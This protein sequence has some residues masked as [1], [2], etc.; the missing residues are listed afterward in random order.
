MDLATNMVTGAISILAAS[1]MFSFHYPKPLRVIKRWW[2]HRSIRI[3]VSKLNDCKPGCF[4][5]RKSQYPGL[6]IGWL[7]K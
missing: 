3:S 6:D 4:M 2:K 5:V 1:V 7:E